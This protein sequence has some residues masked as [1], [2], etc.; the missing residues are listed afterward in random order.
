M[1][2]KLDEVGFTYYLIL[3]RMHDIDPKLATSA[4]KINHTTMFE[5]ILLIITASV[6]YL[7]AISFD[8]S[9]IGK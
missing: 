6:I 5:N 2:E 3:A 8:N 9:L 7:L 1:K 4:A